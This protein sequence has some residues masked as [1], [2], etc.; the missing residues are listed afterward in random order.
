M[1][2]QNEIVVAKAK[3]EDVHD[4]EA[5]V[6]AA[7]SK[8]VER[9]GHPPAPMLEDYTQLLESQD[10]YVLRVASDRKVLGSIVLAMDDDERA[11][12]I[13]NLVVGPSAQGRGYGRIL[14]NHAEHEGRS[15][16]AKAVVLFTNVKMYENIGLY[17]KLGFVETGR[18]VEGP[19]ERVYFRKELV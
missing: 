13:N 9:I 5:I 1:A 8:Y 16:G 11:I 6:K 18:R 19:Y 2:T 15:R 12:K 14:M 7:Y 17:V 3:A 10:V 4:I